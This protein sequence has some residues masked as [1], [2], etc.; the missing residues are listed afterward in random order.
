VSVWT[1]ALEPRETDGPRL[2]AIAQAQRTSPRDNSHEEALAL[3]RAGRA[4][5]AEKMLQLLLNQKRPPDAPPAEELLLALARA[6]SGQHVEARPDLE[7]ASAWLDRQRA[8]AALGALGAATVGP[9]AALP[10]LLAPLPTEVALPGERRPVR[11][12][13]ELLRAEVEQLLAK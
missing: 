1:C 2:A 8:P 10:G 13:L 6:H 7:R 12:E 3:V 9:L 11:A 5:E 4:A